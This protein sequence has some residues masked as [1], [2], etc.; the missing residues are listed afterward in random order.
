MFI[1]CEVKCKEIIRDENTIHKT[2]EL[3][4]HIDIIQW[5]INE[6]ILHG[7][8][9]ITRTDDNDF[10]SSVNHDDKD[11]KWHLK[12]KDAKGIVLLFDL[13]HE[14]GH[15]IIGKPEK[16]CEKNYC[17]EYA[18]WESGWRNV[19]ARFG[20]MFIYREQF[21][22]RKRICLESYKNK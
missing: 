15:V 6:V 17:W 18:A 14:Y 20:K 7:Y 12:G 5:I 9:F 2:N 1:D 10:V 8:L 22:L 4:A 3:A 13:I 21:E 19:S 11:L 16:I